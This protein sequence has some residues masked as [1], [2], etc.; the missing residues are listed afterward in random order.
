MRR[1]L[2]ACMVLMAALA[3]VGPTR[4]GTA[5]GVDGNRYVSPTFGYSV[6]WGDAWSVA[7]EFSESGFDLLELET[8][9]G[10]LWL[11]GQTDFGG[12][13]AACLADAASS[14]DNEPGVENFAPVAEDGTPVAGGD[15]SRAF[16]T[17]SYDLTFDD[18]TSAAAM[19]YLECRT[20]IPGEAVLEI[21][22]VAGS[23]V[24]AAE[25]AAARE[26]LATLVVPAPGEAG[27]PGAGVDSTADRLVVVMEDAAADIDDFWQ[28]TFAAAGEEDDYRTPATVFFDDAVETACGPAAPMEAGPFY[29]PL[30]ETIYM[31]IRFMTELVLPEY[32]EFAAA[33]V[34]AHEWGHH[35]QQ[36]LDIK[37][38]EVHR[39]LSGA[40]SLEIELQADCLA[41]A[42]TRF[43][44]DQGTLAF[45][46]REAAVA[47]LARLVGDPEG[48][49]IDDPAVHGPGSLRA[50]WFL[51]GYYEGVGT[52]LL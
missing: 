34:V 51:K 1:Q 47:V 35:I 32:G 52:C 31:D 48:T 14:L 11:E 49:R 6:S 45:G 33:F 30:D 8:R 37:Q 50:Y 4:M 7:E 36:V 25:A 16:A 5:Q 2:G 26:V 13:A 44:D 17:Y 9:D 15:E 40:T 38:C 42:W 12:D 29:C 3:A 22:H 23:E 21:T 18:G 43:A 27:T 46:D 24:Y 28:R 19:A 20:I 10:I 39:C 41:G